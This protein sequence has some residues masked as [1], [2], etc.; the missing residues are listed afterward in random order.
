MRYTILDIAKNIQ[1]KKISVSEIVKLMFENIKNN[2][3]NAYI[4]TFEESAVKKA[5]NLDD[6]I[7]K[8]TEDERCKL[9]LLYGIPLAIKDMFCTK[10]GKTTGAS[11][12]LENY[13]SPI[14]STI[15]QNF[16]NN[17]AIFIGKAN[18]DE[19]AMGSSNETSYFGNVK[20]PLDKN[21]SAGGS[22]GGSAAAVCTNQ[23]LGS[24]G[25]DTGGSVRLPASYTGLV[26]MRPTYGSCSR[27]GILD[28]A[29]SFDQPGPMSKTVKDNDIILN[30][31]YRYDVKDGQSAKTNKK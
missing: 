22:S 9:P 18:Q 1:E 16:L 6:K 8:L 31:M 17:D 19:H 30:E 5:K 27:Y 11:K 29:N 26:A 13:E 4:S 2:D 23:A 25:T 28:F 21:R 3:V 15:T 20:N 10:E 24:V 14:E 7:K 12:I